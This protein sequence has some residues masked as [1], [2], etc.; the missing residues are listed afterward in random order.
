MNKKPDLTESVEADSIEQA[1][2]AGGNVST[3]RNYNVHGDW[4]LF[5]SGFAAGVGMSVMLLI[6]A[7]CI[8]L[9]IQVAR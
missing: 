7:V 1:N 8:A 6:A 2:I 9:L 3:T 5:A 4:R